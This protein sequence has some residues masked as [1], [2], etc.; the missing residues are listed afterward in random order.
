MAASKIET[1]SSLGAS[2][3]IPRISK[4][5]GTKHIRIAGLPTFFKSSRFSESPAL[6][7]IM[8]NAIFRSSDEIF[9]MEASIRFKAYGPNTIPVTNIPKSPGRCTFL[10]SHPIIM[11]SNSIHAILINIFLSPLFFLSKT[12]GAKN[13]R[14]L[15]FRP[16]SS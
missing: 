11:P 2:R 12:L 6:A 13:K 7:R 14:D 4:Q 1:P 16:L 3:I 5:A 15:K 10:Q 9:K 8:I